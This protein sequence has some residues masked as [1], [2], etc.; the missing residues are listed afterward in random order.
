LFYINVTLCL[1]IMNMDSI[2]SVIESMNFF[3]FFGVVWLYIILKLN[4][5]LNQHGYL[6]QGYWFKMVILQLV[7]L[8]GIKDK[9]YRQ[10][11]HILLGLAGKKLGLFFMTRKLFVSSNKTFLFEKIVEEVWK[12][13]W[14]GSRDHFYK[15]IWRQ[16]K[17]NNC[18][19]FKFYKSSG[20]TQAGLNLWAVSISSKQD[21]KF[22]GVVI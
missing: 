18:Y 7:Q 1:V 16:L 21:L 22:N 3:I 13:L 15:K 8:S 10:T 6:V 4:R 20:N 14:Y 2:R 12:Y 5:R 17:Q 9:E 11:D 19:H